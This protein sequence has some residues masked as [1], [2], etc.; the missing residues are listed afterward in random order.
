[1]TYVLY[2]EY[3]NTARCADHL[4]QR[5]LSVV[6]LGAVLLVWEETIQRMGKNSLNDAGI[7]TAVTWFFALC[8][9]KWR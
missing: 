2:S 5:Y 9:W 4:V 6:S 3:R 7:A 8:T 1:M